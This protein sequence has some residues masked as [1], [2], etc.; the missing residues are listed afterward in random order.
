[1]LRNHL[2][3]A[4]R[5]LKRHKVYSFINIAGLAIGMACAIL[6]LLWIQDELSYDRFHE[7]VNNVYRLV[8]EENNVRYAISHAPFA[9]TLKEE[10]PKILK[11]TRVDL[12]TSQ[13]LIEYKEKKFEQRGKMVD[14]D[15]F[16][17]FTYSFIN[18][19]PRTAFSEP[20]SIVLTEDL[21]EKC[22]VDED[23]IGKILTIDNRRDFTVTG[24]IKNV[25]RN[26]HLKFDFLLSFKYWQQ[27]FGWSSRWDD[28]S[29]YTYVLVQ[30]NASID[31]VN[32]EINNCYKKHRPERKT[33]FYLQSLTRIHLYSDFNFDVAGNGDIRHVYIFT[34]I[35]LMIFIIACINFMNL[36]TARSASRAKEVGIRKVLGSKRMQ[37]IRQFFSES[38]L[39]VFISFLTSLILVELLLPIFSAL[40]E[41]RLS[42]GYFDFRFILTS[43]AIIFVCGIVAGSY[44]AFFLSSFNSVKTIRGAIRSDTGRSIFR[45]ILVVAQF[46]LSIGLIIGTTIVSNQI[47]FM[48]N[49]KL[50]FDKENL[51]YLRL[52][53]NLRENFETL[54][55]ELLRYPDITNVSA[56]SR[57]P[58]EMFDGTT[59]AE[60]EGKEEGK[61]LQ[62]Q[63]LRVDYDYL[64]THKM[65]M[66]QGRFFSEEFSTDEREGV[67]L[68]ETAIK[69]IEIESPIGKRFRY[70]GHDCK[71]IGVIKDFHYRSLSEEVEPLIIGLLDSEW[72]RNLTLRITP[73]NSNFSELV[74]FLES[75]WKKYS[76]GYP[77]EFHFLDESI[78]NLY[79]SE[80]RLSKIFNYFTFLAIFIACLGLFGLASYTAELRTKEIGVRKVLGASISGIVILLTKE[81]SKWVLMANIIAWPLAYY[82]MN[83]WLQNFAYRVDLSVWTFI[84]SGLMAFAIAL[85]TVSFQSI[86][87]ASANPVDSLRYE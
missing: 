78:D 49:A 44:P 33:K 45:K 17:I 37:L 34:A 53:G 21:S 16:E 54:K 20:F 80:Q 82:A 64:D 7:Q 72:S 55:T 36:S 79:V 84:L 62:M 30:R 70:E 51:V 9:Y 46:S 5:N 85:I 48:R 31:E 22:F 83:K 69:T 61:N 77:F 60:W 75:T 65:Q 63:I 76:S 47:N 41:K 58:I 23:P 40:S 73:V 56:S 74:K 42:V 68:N 38:I 50:G 59:G 28:W 24:V 32:Q 12:G 18:G 35:V 13:N 87:A 4:L 15:F 39:L 2:K 71:I 6:I 27:E 57:L 3:I 19:D 1:M 14:S 43:V 8:A 29:Y 10:C 26:S 25:P 66:A 81:F 11:A 67:I 86:K 52:K